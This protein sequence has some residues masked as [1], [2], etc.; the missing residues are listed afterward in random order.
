MFEHAA[1]LKGFPVVFDSA[2]E[3]VMLDGVRT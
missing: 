2:R 1:E 3:G